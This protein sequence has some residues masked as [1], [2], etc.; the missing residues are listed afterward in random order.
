MPILGQ[1]RLVKV[2]FSPQGLEIEKTLPQLIFNNPKSII[3]PG[4]APDKELLK[5]QK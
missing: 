3:L 4:N 5:V 2:S 1:N